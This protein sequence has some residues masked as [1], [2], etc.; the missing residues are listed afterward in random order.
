MW[1]F[2]RYGLF[3]VTNARQGRGRPGSALDPRR[4]QVRARSRKHLELLV[5]RFRALRGYKLI[6]TPSADYRFRII[7]RRKV[8]MR[9][10]TELVRE[11]TY[12]NFKNECHGNIELEDE[13]ISA[14][15]RVWSVG[16]DLQRRV[17]GAGAYGWSPPDERDEIH[18]ED[19][20]PAGWLDGDFSVEDELEDEDGL[21]EPQE[22]SA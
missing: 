1:L 22:V 17:H 2:T 14:L 11:I 12:P 18:P 21:E 16:D 7:V 15:H 9:V 13:Y 3:S 19:Y 5:A 10:A 8:W 20:Y 4:L 6:E